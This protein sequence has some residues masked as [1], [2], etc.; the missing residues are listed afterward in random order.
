MKQGMSLQELLTE[1]VRRSE[2]KHDYLVPT[3]SLSMG[4]AQVGENTSPILEMRDGQDHIITTDINSVAHR[5]IGTALNIPASYYDRMMERCPELLAE[6]VNTWMGQLNGSRMIRTLDGTARAFLSDRYRVIDN[7]RILETVLPEILDIPDLRVESCSVTDEKLYLKVVNPRLTA[8]VTVGDTVQAGMLI[9]NSEVGMGSVTV[10]PLIYR[11]VCTNGMTVNDARTR[12]NHIGRGN[13][14]GESYELY[15]DETLQAD[16]KAFLL[17]L[18][19]TVRAVSDELQF[20]RVVGMM[21]DAKTAKIQ[22]SD[23]PAFVDLTARE[24]SLGKEE[25]NGVLKQLIAAGD[26]SLYGLANA[27]TR[28]SQD[29]ESY[30]RASVLEGVGYSILNMPKGTWNKLNKLAA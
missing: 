16:N 12:K 24:F 1:V 4:L 23:L 13:Q 19:D 2:A 18:R 6:N 28:H 26:L 14:A 15:S 8:D 21:R 30:D 25:S 27:V 5:Q 20:Q 3:A 11:L 22:A 10:Q 17:K 29:V 9:T 7:D